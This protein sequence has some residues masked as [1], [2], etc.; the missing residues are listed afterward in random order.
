MRVADGK[1]KDEEESVVHIRQDILDALSES[2]NPSSKCSMDSDLIREKWKGMV[3]D[4]S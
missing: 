3:P 4:E 2:F 1:T